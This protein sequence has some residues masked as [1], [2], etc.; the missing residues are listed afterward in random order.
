MIEYKGIDYKRVDLTAAIQRPLLK[1]LGYGEDYL[2]P[3]DYF[4]AVELPQATI[5]ALL[6][7][8]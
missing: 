4:V 2:Y 3:A 5:D 8:S 7:A 1:A 6:A